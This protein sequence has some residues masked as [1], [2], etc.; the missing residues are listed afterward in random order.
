MVMN[1]ISIVWARSSLTSFNLS[2]SNHL[3]TYLINWKPYVLRWLIPPW[4]TDRLLRMFSRLWHLKI[5]IAASTL[6]K[7]GMKSTSSLKFKNLEAQEALWSKLRRLYLQ[8]RHWENKRSLNLKLLIHQVSKILK[9]NPLKCPLSQST[10]SLIPPQSSKARNQLENHWHHRFSEDKRQKGLIFHLA[11]RV[12][13]LQTSKGG[14][15]RFKAR[16]ILHYSCWIYQ[17]LWLRWK[18]VLSSVFSFWSKLFWL[19]KEHFKNGLA[20]TLTIHKAQLS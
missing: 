5:W 3:I 6:K 10:T 12:K 2:R 7:S 18:Y 16:E 17:Y 20:K 15:D 8:E 11:V 9:E 1:Q 14:W 19:R 13:T 4:R